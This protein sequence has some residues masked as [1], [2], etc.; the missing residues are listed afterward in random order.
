MSELNIVVYIGSDNFF[1]YV[2][3]IPYQAIGMKNMNQSEKVPLLPSLYATCG[4]GY[5]DGIKSFL[6]CICYK[7]AI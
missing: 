1:L 7:E 5:C 6:F 4:G 3:N 2:S